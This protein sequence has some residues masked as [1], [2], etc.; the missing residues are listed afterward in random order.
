MRLASCSLE[1]AK[2]QLKVTAAV[3][4]MCEDSANANAVKTETDD[5]CEDLVSAGTWLWKMHIQ[6]VLLV[7]I[8]E[9]RVAPNNTND[10]FQQMLFE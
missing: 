2:K 8:D 6:G 1:S 10:F 7:H 4:D 3:D 9:R 5:M